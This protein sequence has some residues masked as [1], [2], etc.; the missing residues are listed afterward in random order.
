[1]KIPSFVWVVLIL[2]VGFGFLMLLANQKNNQSV[3]NAT[4]PVYVEVYADFNCPHCAEFESFVTAAREKYGDKVNIQVKMLPFLTSGQTPD[5]SAE[6]AYAALAA[7]KQAKKEE[8]TELL[9]KWITFRKNPTNTIFTYTD[10]EKQ[11]FAN[12]INLEELAS[13]LELDV[14]KFNIDRV[15]SEV[16]AELLAEKD[17]AVKR[18]GA[19]STPAVFYYGTYQKLSTYNDLDAKID[20]YIKQAEASTTNK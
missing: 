20:S 14:Q 7:G 12:T 18:M 8:F 10:E 9:F 19:I 11:L 3:L 5:T 2:I 1:M 17:S 13:Y 15:S 4:L 6:Y 16:K